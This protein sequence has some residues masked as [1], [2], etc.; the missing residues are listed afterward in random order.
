MSDAG[1]TVRLRCSGFQK[2]ILPCISEHRA[3]APEA[4]GLV[5]RT[6]VWVGDNDTCVPQPQDPKHPKI[7]L[8]HCSSHVHTPPEAGCL[9]ILA[10]D[11]GALLHAAQSTGLPRACCLLSLC[12]ASCLPILAADSGIAGHARLPALGHYGLLRGGSG[13]M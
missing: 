1:N 2:V 8:Q 12:R 6:C 13:E 5:L 11:T 10:A 9:P 7:G 3:T 4:M